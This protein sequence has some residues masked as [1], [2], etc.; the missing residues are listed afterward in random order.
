MKKRNHNHR[1]IKIHRCYTVEGIADLFNIH[2]NTVRIWIKHG[3]PT[4][5][6]KRPMLIH[7]HDLAVFFQARRIKNKKK[8][9][10]GEMYCVRC[11][12]TH[13][14][15]GNMVEYQSINEKLGNLVALCPCC[16]SIMNRRVSLANLVHA[17]EKMNITFPKAQGHIADRTHPTINSDLEKAIKPC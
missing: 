4:I 2:K 15:A 13:V 8:C 1:L 17:M 9:K 12:T 14:P 10:P 5:D 3:L 16:H 11:H 6:D 7:G